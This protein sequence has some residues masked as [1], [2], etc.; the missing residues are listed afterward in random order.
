MERSLVEGV[1]AA[2]NER[3]GS[4]PRR[5][6]R[7][8]PVG[9]LSAAVL[10]AAGVGGAHAASGMPERFAGSLTT[11]L[12]QPQINAGTSTFSAFTYSMPLNGL[13]LTKQKPTSQI[14]PG[15][16]LGATV[17][18]LTSGTTAFSGYTETITYVN[19]PGTQFYVQGYP[20]CT[21][22]IAVKQSGA[23][24]ASLVIDGT[25]AAL[26]FGVPTSSVSALQSGDCVWG[27]RIPSVGAMATGRYDA[28]TRTVSFNATIRNGTNPQS[29]IT[30][31][32]G[33]LTSAAGSGGSKGPTG[34]QDSTGGSGSTQTPPDSGDENC[35]QKASGDEPCTQ[36]PNITVLPSRLPPA[37][38]GGAYRVQLRGLGGQPPYSFQAVGS[39]P[40]GL[41]LSAAG[42]LSGTPSAAGTYRVNL[43]LLDARG[44][45]GTNQVFSALLPQSV[46]LLLRV[47]A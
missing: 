28:A 29:S 7:A 21:W 14:V 30:H 45:V 36:C 35:E 38:V 31:V 37:T 25:T 47:K 2:R 19:Q 43:N 4:S 9:A 46:T 15:I 44:C 10:L 40:G 13:V 26:T 6:R 11:D 42:L 32:R 39:L 1:L 17:Y 8:R 34:P 16:P 20:G 33:K 41:V 3:R 23:L 24:A 22:T 12:V 27:S 18:K 5:Y